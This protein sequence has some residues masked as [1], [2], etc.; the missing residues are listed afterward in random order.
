[1]GLAR[2]YVYGLEDPEAARQALDRA[3]E[4]GYEFGNRDKAMLGDGYLLR[5]EKTWSRAPDFRDLPQESKYLDSVREDCRQA[6]E[7]YE[8]IPAYGEVSRNIRKV[9]ELLQRVEAREDEVREAKL[10]KAGLGI[11][12]P[13]LGKVT[14]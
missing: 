3:E 9:Q 11:L 12:A 6:L 8:T 14:R 13:F 2:T 4:D 10:R 5:A 7:H 1:L